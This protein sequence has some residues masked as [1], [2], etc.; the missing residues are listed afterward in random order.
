MIDLDM[1]RKWKYVARTFAGQKYK[2]PR[3]E[4]YRIIA[5]RFNVPVHSVRYYLDGDGDKTYKRAYLNKAEVKLRIKNYQKEYRKRPEVKLRY[6]KDR[7]NYDL[8]YKSVVRHIDNLFPQIFN[9]N[10]ELPLSEI[11]SRLGSLSGVHLKQS[12][13]ETLLNKYNGKARDPPLIK[14]ELG[15]YRLNPSFYGN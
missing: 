1:V 2:I 9:S 4:I 12:T 10:P 13:L 11:S 8:K 15:N 5:D 14:T 3:N 7:K 6:K